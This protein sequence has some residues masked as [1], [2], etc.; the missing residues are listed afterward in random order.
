MPERKPTLL[1][2]QFAG[3][4]L[5]EIPP[6][7]LAGQQQTVETLGGLIQDPPAI[8]GDPGA[9]QTSRDVFMDFAQNP[10]ESGF[11]NQRQAKAQETISS[12]INPQ[13]QALSANTQA[14]KYDRTPAFLESMQ[15]DIRLSGSRAESNALFQNLIAANDFQMQ[16]AQ[17]LARLDAE[18]AGRQEKSAVRRQGDIKAMLGFQP[19]ITGR[20]DF[21]PVDPNEWL[22]AA[23]G[24]VGGVLTN[25]KFYDWLLGQG[26][27]P[28]EAR[29]IINGVTNNAG[30]I[31]GAAGAAGDIIQG[32]ETTLANFNNVMDLVNAGKTLTPDQLQIFQTGMRQ[33]FHQ[34]APLRDKIS[35]VL[36]GGGDVV[37]T[38]TNLA[39]TAGA[40]TT[41]L[42]MTSGG[43]FAGTVTVGSYTLPGLAPLP[44]SVGA[45][46]TLS[47]A[48]NTML[49]SPITWAAAAAIGGYLTWRHFAG[50]GRKTADKIVP[51]QQQVD[52]SLKETLDGFW[53]DMEEGNI[54]GPEDIANIDAVL[55]ATQAEF[56]S[57]LEQFKDNP[58]A[59][60]AKQDLGSQ[61]LAA[62]ASLTW[63]AEMMTLQEMSDGD[64]LTQDYMNDALDRLDGI[65]TDFRQRTSAGS[66]RPIPSEVREQFEIN[67][68][69]AKDMFG[70]YTITGDA[71]ETAF[72]PDNP[73]TG[74]PGGQAD[75]STYPYNLGEPV[76][77]YDL[78]Q[79]ALQG[80][81]YGT[82]TQAGDDYFSGGNRFVFRDPTTGETAIG[83]MPRYQWNGSEWV[84][85]DETVLPEQ[86]I[87]SPWIQGQIEG[88]GV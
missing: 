76:S 9:F 82:T 5:G 13:T 39:G 24:A 19:T 87:T 55:G 2:T 62:R 63:T 22:S 23:I 40:A 37:G 34:V 36:D 27:S 59:I 1:Q 11:F 10:W 51:S 80:L 52:D 29:D 4:G 84:L 46:T 45:G 41:A 69:E 18:V 17:D 25:D 65:R 60:Q 66:D 50:Q 12:R 28:D 48:F 26:N 8:A 85:E 61:F 57:F 14:F 15:R 67:Y 3:G 43:V 33:G 31:G 77:P 81:P 53:K 47:S 72:L 32:G 83:T 38:V 35:S 75:P 58:A 16:A 64:T 6:W 71:G 7:L 88:I 49:S 79:E 73:N 30:N 42:A 68:R 78:P 54:S 20:E 74:L 56:W 70:Q 21:A 86:D 44:S